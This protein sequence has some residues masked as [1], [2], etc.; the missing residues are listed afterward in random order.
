MVL[1]IGN[2]NIEFGFFENQSL[3]SNFRLVTNRNITSD[4]IGLLVTQFLFHQHIDCTV[5]EDVIIASVVPQIM[6]S[7]NNAMIK[8]LNKKPLI[9]EENIQIPIQIDHRV[10]RDKV[11][12]DR[13]VDAYE[14]YRK[15]RQP[16]IVIDFGTATTFD[17]MT[18]R[19]IY[20]GGPICCGLK[21]SLQALTQN[22]ALLPMIELETPPSVIAT[23]TVT[24]MQAGSVFGFVG[25]VE[26]IVK[27]IQEELDTKMMVIATGGFSTL[28]SNETDK[29]DMVDKALTL[30]G[31]YQI[32][33][34]YQETL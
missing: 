6:F 19:G 25:T 8:Y 11:G 1:D 2:S 31:I 20:Y 18:E 9:L 5:I 4:E 30:R 24:S 28:I 3:H 21:T 29:I 10:E 16:L 23:D 33:R 7:V 27:R 14:A 26:Y 12:C 34:H 17:I 13:L 32:Y 22:A 15:Y